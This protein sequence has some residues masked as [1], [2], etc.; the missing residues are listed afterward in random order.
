MEFG[1]RSSKYF[2]NLENRNYV[3]R[4]FTEIKTEQNKI[5]KNQTEILNLQKDI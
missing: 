4:S 5:V 2:L 3:N 1:E